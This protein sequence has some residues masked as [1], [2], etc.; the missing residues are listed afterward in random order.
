MRVLFRRRLAKAA[1]VAFGKDARKNQEW[2]GQKK[3]R[4]RECHKPEAQP[5]VRQMPQAVAT[6]SASAEANN[7]R[8]SHVTRL[9]Y[10]YIL[11]PH[12]FHLLL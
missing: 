1:F 3:K 8:K 6:A 11:I 4:D 7:D 2:D 9:L 5:A 10:V 12:M